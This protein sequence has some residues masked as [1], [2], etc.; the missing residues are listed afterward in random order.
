MTYFYHR[1]RI[2]RTLIFHI[3]TTNRVLC[4]AQPVRRTDLQDDIDWTY[5]S[6][7]VCR[8]PRLGS[9]SEKMTDWGNREE[10]VTILGFTNSHHLGIPLHV[11]RTY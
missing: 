2:L 6:G 4:T 3:D 7:N 5:Q 1:Q 10:A 11:L 8:H 9:F